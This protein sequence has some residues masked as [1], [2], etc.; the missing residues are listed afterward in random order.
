MACQK[1]CKQGRDDIKMKVKP[2]PCIFFILEY[3]CS[4]R[5]VRDRALQR[6]G[7]QPGTAVNIFIDQGKFEAMNTVSGR[8]VPCCG[9]HQFLAKITVSS[10]RLFEQSGIMKD[11]NATFT[12]TH[13]HLAVFSEAFGQLY[14]SLA[15][16]KPTQSGKVGA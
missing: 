5:D 3:N 9:E 11:K 8:N 13:L 16:H 6:N 1:V 7:R 2:H 14:M 10:Y 4:E 12:T 15:G